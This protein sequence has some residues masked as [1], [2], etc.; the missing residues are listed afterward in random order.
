MTSQQN[1]EAALTLHRSWPRHNASHLKCEQTMRSYDA[2]SGSYWKYCNGLLFRAG[3]L[4]LT[5]HYDSPVYS[6]VRRMGQNA[7]VCVS[8]RGET[9]ARC[10]GISEKQAGAGKS[11]LEPVA[12]RD[13]LLHCEGLVVLVGTL[14]LLSHS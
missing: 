13:H 9:K 8:C 3:D 14:D 5:Q 1:Q 2:H 7:F 6:R 12:L 10:V 4:G 11:L